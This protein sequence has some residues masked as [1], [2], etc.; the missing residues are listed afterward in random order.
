MCAAKTGFVEPSCML[1]R[2]SGCEEKQPRQRLLFAVA[3]FR[4][5]ATLFASLLP[6]SSA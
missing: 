5:H 6:P 1:L 4:A 3:D 2:R